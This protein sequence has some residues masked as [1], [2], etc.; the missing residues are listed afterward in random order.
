MR[1]TKAYIASLGTTGLLLAFSASLLVVVGTLFAFNSWPGADI[2]DAVNSLIVDDEEKRFGIAG[3]AQVALDSAP[4]AFAVASVPAGGS[5]P[6]AAGGTAGSGAIGGDTFPTDTPG[7][8]FGD[9]TDGA[10]GGGGGGL[11][12]PSDGAP[13][14]TGRGTNRLADTT[15]GVTRSLGATV[16]GVNPQLGNT[17]TET[18]QALSDIVRDLPDVTVGRSGVTISG[19]G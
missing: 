19:G 10:E 9:G 4:A 7:G 1:A 15:E 16:G 11:N 2:R 6:G 5:L 13:I 18:G 3:P 14:D 8:G 12:G 17:V